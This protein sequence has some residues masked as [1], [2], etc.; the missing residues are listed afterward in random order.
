MIVSSVVELF[1][2][3]LIYSLYSLGV[4]LSFVIIA[5]V[6][7]EKLPV[8]FKIT[9]SDPKVKPKVRDVLSVC[10]LRSNPSYFFCSKYDLL[11]VSGLNH[12]KIVN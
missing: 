5:Y 2:L 1:S 9:E 6:Q 8:E 10:I 4:A 3:P 7:P 12:T 11:D